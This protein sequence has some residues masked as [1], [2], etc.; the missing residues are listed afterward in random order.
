MNIS[1][2][3]VTIRADRE[4]FARLL[5]IQQKRRVNLRG[6]LAYELGPLPLSISN[7]DGS[8]R[9]TQ[10]SKLFQHL[11]SSIVSCVAIPENCP[12]IFDEMALLQKLPKVLKTFG[13]ISDYIL[14]KVLRGP[15]RA[16]FFV[17]DY[18][19][20]DSIKSME[21]DSRST[22]GTIRIKVVRQEQ[23]IP[24]Q[25]KKF[26]RNSENKLDLIDFLLYDW[27]TN[28]KHSQLL[29]GKEF[30]MTIRVE[31]HCIVHGVISCDRVQELSSIQEEA[32]TKIFLC[33]KFAASLGF[34]SVSII[35]VDSDVAILS[36]YYQHRLDLNIFLQMGIGSKEKLFDIQTNELSVDVINALPA[37]HAL[38][39]C[40]STSSLSGI[41]KVKFFKPVCR[42]E[43]YYNA[44]S[45]LEE[46]ETIN[47]TVADV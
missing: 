6:V 29:D 45:I 18:Y 42:D 4:T 38:S 20:E 10:K 17:T 37:V 5:L 19:L 35:T 28:S 25:W 40:D 14:K 47:A 27:S 33:A 46:S 21:R 24:K 12:Q 23:A 11:E 26:L 9:K 39:G 31:A 43:R 1:N 41:G 44:A 32:D 30:Y 7:Y 22:Y 13:D 36:K 34:E 3:K 15:A 8:L 2:Q 16:D